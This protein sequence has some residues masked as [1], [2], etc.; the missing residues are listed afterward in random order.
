LESVVELR[1]IHARCLIG[2]HY[3]CNHCNVSSS[4]FYL[5]GNVTKTRLHT[6][7]EMQASPWITGN[8]VWTCLQANACV[9]GDLFKPTLKQNQLR[10][11]GVH[12][13]GLK[14]SRSAEA[15]DMFYAPLA[16]MSMIGM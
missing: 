7:S 5:L 3:V 6:G 11:A 8:M 13:R 14:N 1:S 4:F 2:V 9:M 10:L 15:H 12:E 16:T